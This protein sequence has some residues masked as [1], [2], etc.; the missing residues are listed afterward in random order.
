VR[1]A[2]GRVVAHLDMS[3]FQRDFSNLAHVQAARAAAA[4]DGSGAAQITRDINGHDVLV[5]YAKVGGLD[6]LIFVEVP[7][8]DAD[9]P[10][11]DIDC[12]A[13]GRCST[14]SATRAF[15][16]PSATPNC[17]RI[18]SAISGATKRVTDSSSDFFRA[19][20]TP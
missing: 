16:T 6:W 12:G 3:L 13:P 9:V 17:R 18:G 20:A 4:G 1:D 15:S 5:A 19:P 7:V 10:G 11:T 14:T 2:K 8:E